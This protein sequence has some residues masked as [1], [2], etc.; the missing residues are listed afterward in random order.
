MTKEV[1]GI[2]ED[3]L[4]MDLDAL[5]HPFQKGFSD[6]P[7][8]NLGHPWVAARFGGV[9]C[10]VGENKGVEQ[11]QRYNSLACSKHAPAYCPG[12]SWQKSDFDSSLSSEPWL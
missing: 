11:V 7:A 10:D 6:Y 4:S 3:W 5:R 9:M 2:L 12:S 1:L 8:A